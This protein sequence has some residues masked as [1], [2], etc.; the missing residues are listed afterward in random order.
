MQKHGK[1]SHIQ[2]YGSS[3]KGT[4]ELWEAP[5]I[6]VKGF[7]VSSKISLGKVLRNVSSVEMPIIKIVAKNLRRGTF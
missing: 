4:S 7:G 2:K 5:E 3:R 6:D 1:S